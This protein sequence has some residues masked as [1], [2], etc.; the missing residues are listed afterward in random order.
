MARFSLGCYTVR[1]IDKSTGQNLP[2]GD[3]MLGSDL[4][5]VFHQYL[6]ARVAKFSIDHERQKLWRV[7]RPH[8]TDSTVNGIV[9]TGEYGYTADLYNVNTETVSYQRIGTDAEMMPFYFLAQLPTHR[10]EGVILLQRRSNLGIRTIFLKDFAEDFE[11]SYQ[12]FKVVFNPLVPKQLL[13]QYLQD[14]RLTKIRFIRFGLP[15]DLSDAYDAGGHIETEGTAE[16]VLTPGRGQSFPV[17]NRL[18]EVIN[19]RLGVNEMIELHG[20]EYDNVK[21]ELDVGGSKKTLDLSDQLNIRAY[22]DI[23]S[24]IRIDRNGHPE[25]SSIDAVARDLMGSLL[26]ELGTGRRN[27]R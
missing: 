11:S 1:L 16:L 12:G 27:A 26:V 3:S 9:E 5:T 24:D 22:V 23:T 18:L 14:G 20:H 21:V 8:A 6:Q 4:M 25:F 17:V 15:A 10:D 13:N 2:L 7:L 19:G